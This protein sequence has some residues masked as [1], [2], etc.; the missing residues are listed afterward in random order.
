MSPKRYEPPDP[1]QPEPSVTA[2]QWQLVK[3]ITDQLAEQN[4]KETAFFKHL[5]EESSLPTFVKM[6]GISGL[7]V[8]I[9]EVLRMVWLAARYW[10]KF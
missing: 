2:S 7:L 10:W 1:I 9:L 8:L 6:A 4:Q 5:F 3:T